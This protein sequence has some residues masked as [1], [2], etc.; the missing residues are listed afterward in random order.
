MKKHEEKST[1]CLNKIILVV[2]LVAIV[3]TVI[4]LIIAHKNKV[5]EENLK[6]VEA[7]SAQP[8]EA[9]DNEKMALEMMG[10]YWGEDE[11]VY[12]TLDSQD[13]D[14]FTI[15]VREVETTKAKNY[16]TVDIKTKEVKLKE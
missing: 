8:E 2:I 11:T 3:V 13:G 10:K 9:T 14:I 5:R 6:K 16:Y 15:A 12:F 1:S 7:E 4:S